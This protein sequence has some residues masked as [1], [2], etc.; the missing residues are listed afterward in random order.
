VNWELSA[1]TNI[2]AANPNAFFDTVVVARNL[3]FGGVTDL[4]LSFKPVGGNVIWS[5]SFWQTSRTGTNGWLIYDVAGG[6]SNFSNLNLIAANWLDSAGNSFDAVLVSSSFS[7][8][9]NGHSIYLDYT[10]STVTTPEPSSGV[11]MAVVAVLG[12]TAFLSR[13]RRVQP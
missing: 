13:R 1:N 10:A 11:A 7:L 12:G 5:D 4:N 6:I 9:Q 2:N 8:Y 3:N